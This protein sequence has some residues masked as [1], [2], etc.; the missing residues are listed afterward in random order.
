MI[1]ILHMGFEIADGIDF[2]PVTGNLW[3]TENGAGFGDEINLVNPGFNSGWSEVQGIWLNNGRSEMTDISHRP[4]TGLLQGDGTA[5]YNDPQ[6]TWARSIGL[7]ALTFLS[8]TEL[9]EKYENDLLVSDFHNGDIYHFDLSRDR[10]ELLL[11]APLGDK[12][13][14]RDDNQNEIIFAEDFGGI[15]DMQLGPDGYLYVLSLYQ[16][17]SDCPVGE[18]V[19]SCIPYT[20]ELEGAIFRISPKTEPNDERDIDTEDV[21]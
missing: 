10:T 3:D 19:D 8:S 21:D 16:G 17:G 11:N 6:L 20:S 5:Q 7:T 9:G 4:P 14:D 12:V 2:D 1:N 15:T 18:E 13:V